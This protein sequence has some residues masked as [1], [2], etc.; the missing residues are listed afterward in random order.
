SRVGKAVTGSVKITVNRIGPPAVGSAWPAAWFTFTFGGVSTT[1]A[2]LLASDCPAGMVRR[3]MLLFTSRRVAPG[4]R[5]RGDRELRSPLFWPGPTVYVP[6]ALVA[7]PNGV[8]VATPPES[9]RTVR[10]PP[11]SVTGAEKLTVTLIGAPRP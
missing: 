11:T 8:I 4:A 1:I 3:A 10:L 7:G 9:S 6:D 5:T 2:L